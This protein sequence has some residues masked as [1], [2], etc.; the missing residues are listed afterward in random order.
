MGLLLQG[1]ELL[2]LLQIGNTFASFSLSGSFA[3]TM[4]LFMRTAILVGN[5]LATDF[6]IL[7]PVPSNPIV[8]LNLMP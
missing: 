7:G 8:N 1:S 6:N 2:P 4:L 3:V 5:K